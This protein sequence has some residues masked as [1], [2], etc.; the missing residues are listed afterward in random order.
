LAAEGTDTTDGCK[1]TRQY[2]LR[3]SK[4]VTKLM[5]SMSAWL[6]KA[7]TQLMAARAPGNTSC[8][9]RKGNKIDAQHVCL[10]AEVTHT[11]DGGKSARQYI[12]RQFG[13]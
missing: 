5:R 6:P 10:A 1:S 4:R 7:P 8:G 13:S 9:S 2:I 12:L 3:Q 11:T